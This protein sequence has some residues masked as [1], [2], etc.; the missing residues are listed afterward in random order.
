VYRGDSL[1]LY[2]CEQRIKLGAIL[3][4]FSYTTRLQVPYLTPKGGGS[5]MEMEI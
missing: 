3:Y 5:S 4:N 2:S 1:R